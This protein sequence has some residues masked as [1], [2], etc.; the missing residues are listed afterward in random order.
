M[1]LGIDNTSFFDQFL[2]GLLLAGEVGF[3]IFAFLN[4]AVQALFYDRTS[5]PVRLRQAAVQ[6]Q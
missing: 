6:V 5:E 3:C 4:E 1:I 2:D